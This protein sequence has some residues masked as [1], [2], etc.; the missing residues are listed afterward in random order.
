M[1]RVLSASLTKSGIYVLHKAGYKINLILWSQ[2]C[3]N[4]FTV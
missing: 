2:W 3:K 4:R 1:F